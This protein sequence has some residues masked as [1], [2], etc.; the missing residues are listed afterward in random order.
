MGTSRRAVKGRVTG[1]ENFLPAVGSSQS[2][3][4]GSGMAVFW[5]KCQ[6][7]MPWMEEEERP[8]LEF[9]LGN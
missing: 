7:E 1:C 8:V 5:K 2:R 3:V 6:S 9:C 4:L